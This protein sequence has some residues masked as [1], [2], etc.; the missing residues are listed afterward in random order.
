MGPILLLIATNPPGAP[1]RRGSLNS[2]CDS[3]SVGLYHLFPPQ[4][5]GVA[6]AHYQ[7]PT[8]LRRAF[9]RLA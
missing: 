1:P 7:E 4:E 3:L 6:A 8:V 5:L 2:R 9:D